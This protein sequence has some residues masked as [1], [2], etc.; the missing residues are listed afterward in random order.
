MNK[1]AAPVPNI[2]GDIKTVAAPTSPTIRMV[3]QAKETATFAP[4]PTAP[5]WAEVSPSGRRGISDQGVHWKQVSDATTDLSISGISVFLAG[6]RCGRTAGT[7]YSGSFY[8]QHNAA[9]LNT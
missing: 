6:S 2:I 8:T 1:R 4:P 3:A 5:T 9:P 7:R